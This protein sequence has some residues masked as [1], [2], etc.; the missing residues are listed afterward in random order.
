MDTVGVRDLVNRA[1]AILDQLQTDHQPVLVTNR[2]RPVA[3]LSAIDED[4]LHD[5]ILAHAPEYTAGRHRAEA[6]IAAGNH[7]TPLADVI[8]ELEGE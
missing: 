6:G 4:A 8:A 1:S 3:V 7:G 2:G 5:F